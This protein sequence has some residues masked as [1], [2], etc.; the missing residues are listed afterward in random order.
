M[1]PLPA[2]CLRRPGPFVS[3]L[4]GPGRP[5]PRLRASGPLGIATL[6]P[7]GPDGL[8]SERLRFDRLYFDRLDMDDIG[9]SLGTTAGAPTDGGPP[10]LATIQSVTDNPL[11]A[12]VPAGHP[13]AIRRSSPADTSAETPE[14]PEW[15]STPGLLCRGPNRT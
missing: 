10:T 6:D 1:A 2:P 3:A 7:P 11:S 9:P 5:V 8:D 14:G 4:P 12:A 13:A 15:T